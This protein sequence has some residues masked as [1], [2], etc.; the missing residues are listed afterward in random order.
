MFFLIDELTS[1]RVN[2]LLIRLLVNIS[3]C[4]LVYLFCACGHKT[5]YSQTEKIYFTWTDSYGR[6]IVLEK[7]PERIVSLS[8]GITEMVFLLESEDKLVGITDF[9][10]YPPETERITRVGG[11]QNFSV[12]HLVSLAPDVVIIGSIVRKEDVEKIEAMNI[13]VIAIKEEEKIEG[14]YHALDVLGR[15]LGKEK[16]ATEEIEVLKEKMA[17]INTDISDTSSR[18]SL[19]YVVGY[20]DAGD[21]TAPAGTHIHEILTLAG[22]R[23][24]G[25]GLKSWGMS[26]EFLFQED[27]DYIVIRKE[28]VEHFTKTYP[29]T[30]LSAVIHGRVIPI[31]SGWID[32]VS[33]RNIWATEHINAEIKRK[34]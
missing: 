6:E 21:F 27:P 29:Y 26:R 32:I 17:K 1:R 11:M 31:E 2:N 25:A 9:C 20:N 22:G 16:N 14:I 5:E 8:P 4:L 15:I 7:Q 18:P 19:Y 3:T 33:P 13:P 23:N 12:E 30:G 28:D 10:K 24:I 34:K